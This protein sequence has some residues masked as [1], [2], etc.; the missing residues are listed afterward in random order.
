MVLAGWN[1]LRTRFSEYTPF[2]S[3]VGLYFLRVRFYSVVSFCLFNGNCQS[4]HRFNSL[5]YE[6]RKW[7]RGVFHN[8]SLNLIWSPLHTSCYFSA[9]DLSFTVIIGIQFWH[10]S[11]LI[12]QMELQLVLHFR[13]KNLD[14]NPR[15]LNW[16]QLEPPGYLHSCL[17]LH[18]DQPALPRKHTNANTK[19]NQNI[20]HTYLTTWESTDNSCRPLP[21]VLRLA[22]WFSSEGDFALRETCGNA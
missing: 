20:T 5:T 6:N 8:L 9:I 12:F 7:L 19:G 15:G 11:K 13:A 14:R 21:K 18:R 3:S 1:L 22:Q 17:G 10:D 2:I 16:M 4:E